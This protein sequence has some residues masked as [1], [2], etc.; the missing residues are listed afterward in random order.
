M[1]GQKEEDQ[2]DAENYNQLFPM[3]ELRQQG[4]SH[5]ESLSME[6]RLPTGLITPVQSQQVQEMAAQYIS[7]FEEPLRPGQ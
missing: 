4:L 3:L 1:S 2:N 6:R 7:L 5:I